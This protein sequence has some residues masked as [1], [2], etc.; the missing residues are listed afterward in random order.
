MSH[1][2]FIAAAY[3]FTAVVLAGLVVWVIIDGRIQ[4]AALGELERRGIRRSARQRDGE[5]T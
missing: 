5:A 4:Q 3:A 1:I 2:G